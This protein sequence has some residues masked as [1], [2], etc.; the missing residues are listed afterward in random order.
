MVEVTAA[1]ITLGEKDGG[2]SCP[3]LAGT[4]GGTDAT[5]TGTAGGPI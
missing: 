5:M 2:M 4:E 1:G 3:G